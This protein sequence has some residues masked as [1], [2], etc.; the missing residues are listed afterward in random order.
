M[1]VITSLR[2]SLE[3]ALKT[4][5]PTAT[6]PSKSVLQ[7]GRQSTYIWTGAP[8]IAKH[9]QQSPLSVANAIIAKFSNSEVDVL[10]VKSN[11]LIVL[12]LKV[13]ALTKRLELM[14]NDPSLGMV[15]PLSKRVIVDLSGPNIA[16]ELHVGHLRSTIIGDCLARVMEFL[17]HDVLRLNH[18]GDWGTQFGMLI[19]YLQENQININDLDLPLLMSCYRESRKLF[20]KNI[21]FKTRS[22]EAVTLLQNGDH[23]SIECWQKICEVSRKSFQEIY[24]LLDIKIVERGESF[25]NEFLT[26]MVEELIEK[27]IAV[28]SEGAICVFDDEGSPFMLRKS[29]GG[30]T[31]DTTDLASLRHRTQVEM[32][33]RLIYV[34]DE[35]QATHFKHLVRVGTIAGYLNPETTNFQHVGF[36]VVLGPDGQ[37]YKTRSGE[38]ALL[39]DLVSE[40]ISRAKVTLQARSIDDEES[41]RILGIGALKYADLKNSRQKDYLF[42]ADRMLA[43]NGN[44]AAYL[45]YVLTRIRSIKAK[46]ESKVSI[47]TSFELSNKLE[48]ELGIQLVSFPDV[49]DRVDETLEPHHLCEFLYR[50]AEKFN[51]FYKDCP[52]IE[53][54]TCNLSR[55][56]LCLLVE[57]VLDKGLFL[58]GIGSLEKM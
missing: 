22:R 16:K 30:Y 47:E 31:Y 19:H 13:E 1:T 36:G 56:R 38:V 17:Q 21:D 32:G 45:L 37:K 55:L 18:V 14:D 25:Y 48:E 51:E 27:G 9:L 42:D 5:F 26:P 58:L 40:A 15:F 46:S 10:D 7:W 4:A 29:D 41:A 33:K 57:K 53:D 23:F 54:K 52:V 28:E 24:D 44:T 34:V 39:K 50:V 6:A 11:G 8:A 3:D 12:A 2:N 35:G 20:D 43:F 49:I